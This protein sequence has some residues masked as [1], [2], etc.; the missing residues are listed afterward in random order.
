MKL[1]FHR[2][3]QK[4]SHEH[5]EHPNGRVT[6]IPIHSNQEIGGRLYYSIL[7][8]LGVDEKRFRELA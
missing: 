6:T 2:D 5:W 4:G 7:K 1:G 8:Q 3:R